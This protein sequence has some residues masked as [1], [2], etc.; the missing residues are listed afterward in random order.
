MIVD[1]LP[2]I[3]RDERLLVPLGALAFGVAFSYPLIGSLGT[4]GVMFDWDF[5]MGLTWVPY[6]TIVRYHQLPLWNPYKCGGLPMLANPESHVLSPGF[7]LTLLF[8]PFAGVQLEVPI[9]LAI[10][11]AGGYL[12]ARILKI[13]PLGAIATA[14][15]FPA[16]SWF[17][18][19]AG[20]GHMWALECVSCA[21]W[22]FAFAWLSVERDALRYAAISGAALALMFLGIG[23][24]PTA[25]TAVGIAALLTAIALMRGDLRPFKILAAIGL[26]TVGFSAAKLVPSFILSLQHPRPT[27]DIEV[28]DVGV[29]LTALFA[30]DQNV[31]RGSPNG[32]GFWESGAYIG[33]FAVPALIGFAAPRRGAPWIFAAVILWLLARGD[34]EPFA[35]WPILHNLP[36]FNSLRLPSRFLVPFV[37]CVGVMAGMGSDWLAH[38][39]PP[40][41]AAGAA[42]MIAIAT[43]DCLLVGPPSLE[44][45]LASPL[46]EVG[47]RAQVF[48]QIQRSPNGSMLIPAMEN[49]GVVECRDYTVWSTTV[50]A[51]DQ[52]GYRGEQYVLGPGSIEVL[53]WTPNAIT[54][55]LDV[56]AAAEIV[57]NQNYS[58]WWRVAQG[59]GSVIDHDGL[60][61][62]R[63][64]AGRQRLEL[65]YRDYSALLGALLT[66]L[67]IAIAVEITRRERRPSL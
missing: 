7:L 51:S 45:M 29:L 50:R 58:R 62:V 61:G 17:F 28:N 22:A 52:P 27:G 16:S 12:L 23:P 55:D 44:M 20:V 54:Y 13:G 65:G 40:W 47:A 9:R 42:A 30:R 41:G 6:Q 67:T 43:V 63:V 3:V 26:F 25:F 35:V 2:R 14:T 56:P 59:Q 24:Y 21:P 8:G 46:L 37:L 60:I 53:R 18:L 31:F 34:A 15:V 38:R 66:I 39:W 64:P 5:M 48:H 57:V 33:L 49:L 10:G 4:R 1:R 32:W 36:V 11:W 19:K